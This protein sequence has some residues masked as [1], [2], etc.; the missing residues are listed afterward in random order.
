[1][2]LSAILKCCLINFNFSQLIK[3][4]FKTKEK[5]IQLKSKNTKFIL[6]NPPTA[7]GAIIY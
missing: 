1:M 4:V 3:E 7:I 6:V 2:E 5:D